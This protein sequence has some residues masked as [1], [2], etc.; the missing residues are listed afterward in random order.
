MPKNIGFRIIQ[1]ITRAPSDLVSGFSIIPTSNISDCMNRLYCMDAG[2]KPY[3]KTQLAGTAFTIKVPA[4]DNAMIHYALDLASPGDILVIAASGGLERALMGEIMFTYAEKR[5]ISGIIV[6]GAIRDV[7][8]L[9][10]LTL[11]VYAR[12]VTP[13]G[14]YK[15]GPGEINVPI[16][17]AGQVVNPGDIIIGDAD[18]VVVIPRELAS[19]L[20]PNAQ[21]KLA[22]EEKRLTGY[23]KGELDAEAHFSE[24]H[25]LLKKLGIT[26]E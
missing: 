1:E 8:C 23:R 13:Q 20:L 16:A 19:E 25:E 14:P 11:P 24:Y 26:V 3:G 5:G 22:Q 12:G 6:D 18:G 2:I 10:R 21:A 9:S 4:S 17:C 15:V 7:D